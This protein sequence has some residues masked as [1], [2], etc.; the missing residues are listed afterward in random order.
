MTRD[1][2][3]KNNNKGPSFRGFPTSEQPLSDGTVP[4]ERP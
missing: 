4:R 2:F 1:T 3:H